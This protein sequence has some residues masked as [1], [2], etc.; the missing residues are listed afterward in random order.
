MSDQRSL[1]VNRRARHEYDVLETYQA[2]L[3]LTG[4]EI[5]SARAG[6]VSLT[7]AYARVEGGEVWIYDMHIAPYEQGNRFNVDPRRKRKLLLHRDEIERLLGNTQQKGLTLVPL[8]MYLSHGY[9]KLEIGLA[10]GR[11]LYDR[12]RAIAEREQRREAERTLSGKYEG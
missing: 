3:A 2:G 1:A 5:K 7:E 9:A 12:R 6:K 8:R 4:T 10:R 11:K